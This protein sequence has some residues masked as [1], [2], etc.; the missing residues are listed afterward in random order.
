MISPTEV[1]YIKLGDEGRWAADAIEHGY[2][3][4]GYHSIPHEVCVAEDREEVR[5]L[6]VN[7]RR[8][9]RSARNGTKPSVRGDRWNG[10]SY[11]E[12]TFRGCLAGIPVLQKV[13]RQRT[14]SDWGSS[15]REQTLV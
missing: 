7:C 8:P 2:V 10:S 6:L 15:L 3:A 12:P 9:G 4:F 5:R 13:C 14:G 11:Q 1:R